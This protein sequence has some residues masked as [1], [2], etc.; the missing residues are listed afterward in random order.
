MLKAWSIAEQ[1][2]QTPHPNPI[3]NPSP[4][5]HNDPTTGFETRG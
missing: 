2:P 1:A 3:R 5:P 4:K